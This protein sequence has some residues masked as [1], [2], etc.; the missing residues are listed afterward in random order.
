MK[1]QRGCLLRDREVVYDEAERMLMRDIQSR[2]ASGP[3]NELVMR[4]IG[5]LPRARSHRWSVPRRPCTLFGLKESDFQNKMFSFYCLLSTSTTWS[6]GCQARPCNSHREIVPS[7]KHTSEA[8][9]TIG[10]TLVC[11]HA[12]GVPARCMLAYFAALSHSWGTSICAA[13][14]K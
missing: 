8:Y 7:T 12:A 3:Q 6:C 13:L 14:L 1:K 4:E 9:L 5:E 10:I 2:A 11:M